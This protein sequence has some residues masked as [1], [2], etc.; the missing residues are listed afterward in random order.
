[1]TKEVQTPR[2][3]AGPTWKWAELPSGLRRVTAVSTDHTRRSSAECISIPTRAKG[4]HPPALSLWE[5]NCRR[6]MQSLPGGC[7]IT[8]KTLKTE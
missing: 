3:T 5:G 7:N 6:E 4:S 2:W 1:M 8:G